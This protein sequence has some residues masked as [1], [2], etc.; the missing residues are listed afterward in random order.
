MKEY[1]ADAGSGPLLTIAIPTYNRSALLDLCLSQLVP[2]A[3]DFPGRVE[4]IVSDNCSSDDTESVVRRHL[5]AGAPVRYVRNAENVGPDRNFVQCFRLA[6]GRYFL[7]L[8][9]DDVLLEGGLRKLLNV[10]SE[11]ESGIVHLKSYSFHH[12]FRTERPRHPA[13]GD[14]TVY[15]DRHAF[16]A[17]VNVMF[18]FISGNVVDRAL[19]GGGP[20]PESFLDTN[21]VQLAWVLT[22]LIGSGRHVYLDD[23]VI[24]AKADN[25]GGYRLCQAFGV[26]MNRVFDSFVAQGADPALFKTINEIVLRTFFPNYIVSLR[27][28]GSDFGEENYYETL[29]PVYKDYPLF[30]TMV[31]P[32]IRLPLPLAKAWLKICK[33]WFKLTGKQPRGGKRVSYA[34]EHGLMLAMIRKGRSFKRKWYNRILSRRLPGS[35]GLDIHP[36]A[37]IL[38]LSHITIGKRFHAGPYLRLEAVDRFAGKAFNPRIVIKDNVALNDF[39]HIG[40][41]NYVEIGNDVL[42]ASKIFISDHNHGFYAGEGQSD[43]ETPPG[44]RPLDGENRVII[45]DN[46]WIGEFVSILPG[47]TIGRG[48]IVGANSVVSRDIPPHSIA[49]GSPARVV[50]RYDPETKRWVAATKP[51]S[52]A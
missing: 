45:E 1:A 12:D 42:M 52:P 50:K 35:K 49:V 6:T 4:L 43:P 16:T 44:Q 48:S 36:T 27:K 37:H 39:V 10:L 38:G 31:W 2:Q 46:V 11:G 51:I 18:T 23:Y 26:N 7:L 47:V 28:E 34:K 15:T 40:A 30:W 20:A 29:H 21:M 5:D 13:S 22:A 19:A 32:A 24:A 25:T 17:R 9:D 8:G 33:K 41:T 14:V 3:A